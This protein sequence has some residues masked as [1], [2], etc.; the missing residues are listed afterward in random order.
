MKVAHAS[1]C[2]V[3][4]ELVLKVAHCRKNHNHTVAYDRNRYLDAG[5]GYEAHR[6]MGAG[7][8]SH[9]M[10]GAHAHSSQG[11][12]AARRQ[13]REERQSHDREHQEHGR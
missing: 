5:N 6:D 12:M 4:L 2:G 7:T 11:T 13:G 3:L 10:T 8:Q 1:V 9:G